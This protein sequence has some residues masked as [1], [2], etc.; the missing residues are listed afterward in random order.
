MEKLDKSLMKNSDLEKLTSKT[1]SLQLRLKISYS[2]LISC[3]IERSLLLYKNI[4][5]DKRYNLLEE[6]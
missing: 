2:P 5:T 4:L 1:N 6:N 3:E